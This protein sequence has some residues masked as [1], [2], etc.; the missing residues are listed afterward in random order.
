MSNVQSIVTPATNGSTPPVLGKTKAKAKATTATVLTPAQA[1]EA[2]YEYGSSLAGLDGSLTVAIKYYKDNETVMA[3]MLVSLNVGYLVRKMGYDK[4]K[5]TEVVGLLK[6]NEKKADDH[7]RTFEQQRIMDTVR[8]VWHRAQKMA[9]VV[10]AKSENQVKAEQTRAEKEAEKT[11]H[12]SRLIKADEIVNPKDDT[13]IFESLTRLVSTMKALQSKH[14]GKLVGD[15][16]T[17]WRD[18]L[19]SAPSSK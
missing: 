12:E 2:A 15:K 13:D 18:W 19:A 14:A 6:Y 7:H 1:C 9:G 4:A 3:D 10:K 5:A 16:G 11:A 8:V 17:A